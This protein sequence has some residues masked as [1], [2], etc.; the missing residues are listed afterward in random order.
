MIKEKDI[1]MK[2]YSFVL[3]FIFSISNLALAEDTPPP[4]V[5]LVKGT[6]KPNNGKPAELFFTSDNAAASTY[7]L[8]AALVSQQIEIAALSNPGSVATSLKF[9]AGISKNTV[10]TNGS[11]KRAVDATIASHW[12]ITAD[13]HTK[14]LTTLSTSL[15]D[16]RL[17]NDRG[18]TERL[19]F[20]LEAPWLK[21]FDRADAGA[22][23]GFLKIFPAVGLYR[24]QV[25]STSDPVNSPTGHIGGQ[26]FGAHLVGSLGR[27]TSDAAWFERIGL[28]VTLQRVRD[29]SAST[30]FTTGLYNFADGTLSYALYN[31][32]S[33]AWKPS[34]GLTRTVGTDRISD[35]LYKATT[36]VGLYLSYGI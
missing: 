29:S 36:S 10:S 32:D 24:D 31:D 6:D 1:N 5:S 13:H 15:D 8:N 23:G 9:S 17:K 18:N 12:D 2:R 30:G 14:L 4:L 33:S 27:V 35:E 16:N 11:D 20:E 21:P 34:I 25:S 19:D 26:Y 3:A 22:K 7:A 28:D